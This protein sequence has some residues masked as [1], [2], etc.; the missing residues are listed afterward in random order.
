MKV[1][2][3]TE[4]I[5]QVHRVLKEVEETQEEVSITR[6]GRVIARLLPF[7]PGMTLKEFS[8]R[9]A[10]RLTSKRG[11]A[12]LRDIEGF[13]RSAV[14]GTARPEGGPIADAQ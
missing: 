4:F 3:D 5:D 11:E 1:M 10:G 7:P 2:T 9:M 14:E 13:D 12:W 8:E 6:N